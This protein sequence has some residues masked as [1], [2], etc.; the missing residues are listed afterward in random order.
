MQLTAHGRVLPLRSHPSME[1][2]GL[3]ITRAQRLR[4]ENTLCSLPAHHV[5]GLSYVELRQRA[6]SGGSTNALPGRTSGPGYSIVLDYD[7]FSR[8][9]NQTTLDLNYTLL[10]EMGH[11]VDWTNHAFSWMQLNDRPGYDAICARVHRH[12]PGGTNNDQE[13][14]AD[15]YADFHF[16]TARGRRTWPDSIAAI[17]R[18]R[19]IWRVPESRPPAGGWGAS[20]YA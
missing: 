9:I 2:R 5:S 16:A 17:E 18:C 20:A 15:A 8:R 12:A 4:L 7:S 3:S 13:K 14:F 11:V 19:P 1:R 10:H 6:G